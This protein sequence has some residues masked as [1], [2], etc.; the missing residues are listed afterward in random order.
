MSS[1]RYPF[2]RFL[3]RA[4]VF[5]LVLTGV[6]EIWTR[7]VTPSCDVPLSYLETRDSVF[8]YDPRGPTHGTWTIGRWGRPTGEWRVNNHG[9]ISKLDYEE[10]EHA[11]IAT[12]ALLGDSYVEGFLTDIDE[13]LDVQLAR[14]MPGTRVY[15]FGRSGSY[16][17]QHVATARYVAAGFSP[18]LLVVF[19]NRHD[20]SSSLKDNG[21]GSPYTW[22][23]EPIPGGFAEIPP[24][25][26]YEVSWK[27]RLTRRSALLGYL[28]YNAQIPLPG[29]GIG[30]I[31]QPEAADANAEAAGEVG[32][33]NQR[34]PF[35]WRNMVPPATYMVDLLCSQN[36]GTP[37][38]FAVLGGERYLPSDHITSTPLF[39]DALAIQEA[40][41]GQ[42]QCYFLD[43][44]PA[45][46]KDWERHHVRF[47]AAD[48]AHWNAYANRLVVDT[49]ACFIEQQHLLN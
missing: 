8:R 32:S 9:W 33:T 23:I 34:N 31:P 35:A 12:I 22:K 36:P 7:T 5:L 28:I 2:L 3:V 47:E 42:T 25:S 44:R 17:E 18:D 24:S 46:S 30:A 19:V 41:Q 27:S 40:C 14:L 11:G 10:S 49:L 21:T 37:I 16:L 6:A 48:G 26:V 20:V 29:M 43:L 45:F 4:A 13:H 39:D 38:V 15:S 1:S